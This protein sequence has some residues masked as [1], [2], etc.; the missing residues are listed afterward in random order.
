MVWGSDEISVFFETLPVTEVN[1]YSVIRYYAIPCLLGDIPAAK[2]KIRCSFG[3]TY[4][5][6]AHHWGIP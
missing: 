1:T 3:V 5:P 2:T 4:M 6:R